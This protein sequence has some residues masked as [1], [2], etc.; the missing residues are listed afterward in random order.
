M[1][2]DTKHLLKWE[3]EKSIWVAG[4]TRSPF[5]KRDIEN[6]ISESEKDIYSTKQLRKMI[7]TQPSGK[8]N[9][10]PV[11][12]IDLF[13]FDEKNRRAGIGILIS[14]KKYRGKGYASEAL[15]IM[16]TYCFEILLLHQLYC[17]I[18]ETNSNSL[19]LFKRHGFKITGTKKKW[20][21]TGKKYI[22]VYQLQLIYRG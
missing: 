3:N 9:S 8:K 4:T 13:D 12:C 2:Y 18:A 7:C 22:D 15:E 6:F 11:G 19:D 17:D 1:P 20:I 21:L 16:T 10:T 5:T 14:E